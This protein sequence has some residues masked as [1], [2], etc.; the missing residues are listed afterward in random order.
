[1]M[2]D[3][4]AMGQSFQKIV[5]NGTTGYMSAQGQKKDFTPEEA[6]EYAEQ[7]RMTEELDYLSAG[8]KIELKGIE[9][10]DNEDAYMIEVTRPSGGKVN[11]YYQVKSGLKV[12]S[13]QV[14]EEGTQTTYYLD[15]KPGA[16]N[17]MYPN[18][19]KQNMGPQMMELKF[20]SVEINT[21]VS[22]DMFK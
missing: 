10:V 18:L 11:E 7:A 5:F 4:T 15:Y 12:K 8:Y 19:I 2:L 3:V 13:E 20:Q 6:K 21:N 9:K 22:E 1:M 17:L 16:G 14:D